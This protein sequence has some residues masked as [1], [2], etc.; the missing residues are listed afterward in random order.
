MPLRDR[1]AKLPVPAP[2]ETMPPAIPGERL[3]EPLETKSMPVAAPMPVEP[4]AAANPPNE[5][6]PET[7]TA[8]AAELL[9]PRTAAAIKLARRFIVAIPFITVNPTMGVFGSLGCFNQRFKSTLQ[10]RL[11]AAASDV[12][13]AKRRVPI[14][15][16]K[17]NFF[18][19]HRCV[20]K[21]DLQ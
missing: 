19:N 2:I 1:P 5:T 6:W 14:D 3:P 7:G 13:F 21:D 4:T 12:P 15:I 20:K 16:H 10:R 11:K 9:P 17:D 18:N 8:N